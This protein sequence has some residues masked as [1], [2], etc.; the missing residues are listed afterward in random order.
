MGDYAYL[1]FITFGSFSTTNANSRIASL[2]SQRSDWGAGFDRPFTNLSFAPTVT[3]LRGSHSLRGGY[4]LRIRAWDIT[5]DGYG[6]GRY[7]FTGTYTRANNAAARTP[8][9]S[10]GP[11][12]CSA[13]PRSARTP[14]PR[15][16]ARASQF[17]ISA[18]GDYA[19][20]RTACSCRT[21]GG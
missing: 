2:G 11:S 13:F 6:A 12:S 3:W 7:H 4:D 21:T 20:P 8:W 17:E 9:R 15:R 10:R 16:A 18:Q 5:N 19:R 1:P 14:S